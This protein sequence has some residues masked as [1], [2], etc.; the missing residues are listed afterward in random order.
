MKT[1]ELRALMAKGNGDFVVAAVNSIPS[2]LDRIEALEAAL[3]D[4]VV[5][6]GLQERKLDG[7]AL[8]RAV[9]LLEE[10]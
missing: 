10:T 1:E 9:K 7:N 8:A 4:I 2:L 3:R 6:A 5:T